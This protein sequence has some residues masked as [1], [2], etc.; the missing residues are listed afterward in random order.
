MTDT[1][2]F[3]LVQP[4]TF[5]DRLTEVLRDGARAL[6]AQAVETEVA[7]FIAEHAEAITASISIVVN[8]GR[9]GLHR[10][11]RGSG[12][13]RT[14]YKGLNGAVVTTTHR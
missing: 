14:R 8:Q 10:K 2:V 11:R 9:A 13:D 6:L 1:N 3:Q 12:L 4:G 5:T 7:D